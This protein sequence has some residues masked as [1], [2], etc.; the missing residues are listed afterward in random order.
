MQEFQV[1][2]VL[3]PALRMKKQTV[4]NSRGQKD[5]ICKENRKTAYWGMQGKPKMVGGVGFIA[6]LCTA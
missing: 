6:F 1:F 5:F 3:K 2:S 4:S